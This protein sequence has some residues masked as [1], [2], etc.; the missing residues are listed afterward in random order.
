MFLTI[1]FKSYNLCSFLKVSHLI[2]GPM[3]ITR[4]AVVEF[5]KHFVNI[6]SGF[7]LP[8]H[9][10]RYVMCSAKHYSEGRM[11]K[12]NCFYIT[13]ISGTPPHHPQSQTPYFLRGRKQIKFPKLCVI[14]ET[15]DGGQ[16]QKRT[17]RKL[18]SMASAS[19]YI[20]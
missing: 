18:K 8:D 20:C 17:D 12:R 9:T 1:L 14:Y 10:F 15:L 13:Q 19:S 11:L 3:K 4:T 5:T 2:S 16:V 6:N 7:S